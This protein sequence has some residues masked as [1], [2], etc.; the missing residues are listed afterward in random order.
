MNHRDPSETQYNELSNV[1]SLGIQGQELSSNG[2]SQY[3]EVSIAEAE[4]REFIKQ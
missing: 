4:A 3:G 2:I 1:A